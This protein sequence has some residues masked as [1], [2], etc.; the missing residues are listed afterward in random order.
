MLPSSRARRVIFAAS[1]LVPPGRYDLRAHRH[2]H[3]EEK[4]VM[5]EKTRMEEEVAVA[6][7]EKWKQEWVPELKAD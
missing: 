7:R 1:S 3:I 6:K 2:S 5:V 4:P